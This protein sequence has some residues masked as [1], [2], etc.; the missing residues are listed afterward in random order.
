MIQICL[1]KKCD[2][3]TIPL[4]SSSQNCGLCWR[5]S[6]RKLLF[7]QHFLNQDTAGTILHL[8]G[9]PVKIF[10]KTPHLSFLSKSVGIGKS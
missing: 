7:V 3:N 2:A 6:P 1:I 9:I 10:L 5:Q 4:L 8:T